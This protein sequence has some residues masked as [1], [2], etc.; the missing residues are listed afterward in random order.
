MVQWRDATGCLHESVS[1]PRKNS[2]S[3]AWGLGMTMVSRRG[4]ARRIDGGLVSHS[5]VTIAERKMTFYCS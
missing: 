5:I 3:G 2:Q 1:R 4:R